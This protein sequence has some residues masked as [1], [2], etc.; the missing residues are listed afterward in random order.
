MSPVPEGIRR[1]FTLDELL[2]VSFGPDNLAPMTETR[3]RAPD[4]RIAEAVEALARAA[5]SSGRYDCAIVLGTGLGALA[6]DVEDAIALPYAEI[7]HFP[8]RRGLRP[9]RAAR[10]RHARSASGC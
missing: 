2:P 8:Q 3:R 7:P 10:C 6:D 9:C 4:P 5:A 1:S